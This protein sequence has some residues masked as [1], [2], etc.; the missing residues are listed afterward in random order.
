MS[1]AGADPPVRDDKEAGR[2][3][4][5]EKGAEAELVYDLEPGRLLL[6]H[7]EVP[8][9]FRGRGMG[10]VLVAAAVEKARREQLTIVPWCPYARKWLKEHPD[11]LDSVDVDFRTPPPG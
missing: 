5:E 1:A 10:A 3:V 7:T 8:E 11:A 9:A 6:L 4:I 2:F